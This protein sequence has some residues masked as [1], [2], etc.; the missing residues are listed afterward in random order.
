MASEL[1]QTTTFADEAIV[2]AQAQL[3]QYLGQTKITKELTQATLDFA[4]AMGMDL[5]SAAQIVG[6]SIGSNNNL[7]ARY[8]VQVDESAMKSTKLTEVVN[9]LERRFGGQ[10]VAAAQGLGSLTQMK[11]AMG[12][13]LEVA[14]ER[15]APVITF[16]AKAI[17]SFAVEIQE[18]RDVIASFNAAAQLLGKTGVVVKNVFV[19][20]GEVIGQVFGT[21]VGAVMQLAD[22]QFKMAFKTITSGFEGTAGTI[23]DRYETLGKDLQS[24]DEI[25]S[26]QKEADEQREIQRIEANSKAKE[27][28]NRNFILTQEQMFAARDSKEI[29]RLL[30][31]E[32]L[33][34]DSQLRE[35][36]QRINRETDHTKKLELELQKRE[37]LDQQYG[38]ADRKRLFDLSNFKENLNSRAM[39]EFSSVLN[40]MANMQNSKSAVLVGIGKSA[41]LAQ[42]AISTARGA[43]EAYTFAAAI[44][45]PLAGIALAAPIVAYGAERSAS[46]AGINLAEGGIVKA[47]PGGVMARIGEGGKDEAVI[48]LGDQGGALFGTKIQ[49]TVYGGLLG[50]ETQAREFARTVDYELLKLRQSNE[51]MAFDKG[52]I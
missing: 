42:M 11:N 2:A 52:V 32:R 27:D 41:A 49:L 23:S 40:N 9:G 51:S 43:V 25:F 39:N 6:K 24:I 46:I 15:L 26:N 36:N 38:D 34:G 47:T 4:S 48:P 20:L 28:I 8:G 1:Q 5:E 14:G 16:A 33:K 30:D 13:I 45:G 12:D 7:L 35:I 50:N 31:Q 44:G 17:A 29:N 3:Q 19:G 37:F 18:N 10:A 22:R 21:L